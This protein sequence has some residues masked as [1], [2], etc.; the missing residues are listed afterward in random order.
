MVAILFR[1]LL[2]RFSPPEG[3]S[4]GERRIAVVD[5]VVP[6]VSVRHIDFRLCDVD[7][8]YMDGA[9]DRYTLDTEAMARDLRRRVA[10]N[11]GAIEVVSEPARASAIEDVL[12]VEPRAVPLSC[13]LQPRQANVP[14]EPPEPCGDAKPC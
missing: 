11:Y 1:K 6:L 5:R 9:T 13:E 14:T 8:T 4:S 2:L 3:C 12:F 7:I 10:A